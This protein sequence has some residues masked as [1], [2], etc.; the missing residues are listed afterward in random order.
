MQPGTQL[1]LRRTRHSPRVCEPLLGHNLT[2]AESTTAIVAIHL[3]SDE[4]ATEMTAASIAEHGLRVKTSF[5]GQRGQL[6]RLWSKQTRWRRVRE[7]M[8]AAVDAEGSNPRTQ[9]R[10]VHSRHA[11]PPSLAEDELVASRR[12]C[13]ALSAAHERRQKPARTAGPTTCRDP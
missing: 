8:W 1:R 7:V 11:G 4:P 6:R 10:V 3:P 5:C 12:A 2:S 13:T 9:P